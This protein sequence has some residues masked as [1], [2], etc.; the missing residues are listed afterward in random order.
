[1]K[2]II[3]PW[4]V[5][6]V[7]HDSQLIPS[8]IRSQF[9]LSVE[10]L[11]DELLKMT[12]HHT[13]ALFTRGVSKAQ[14]V[15]SKISRLVVDVERFADDTQ[16]SMSKVGMGVIYTRTHNGG[17]L[18]SSLNR[19]QRN[20]L[21]SKWYYPHHLALTQAVESSL[22]SYDKCLVIDCHSFPSMP[23]PYESNKLADRPEICIGT[24]TYHT[25]QKLSEK[26]IGYF[27]N[28][29]LTVKQNTPFSDALVPMPFYLKDKR[30]SSVM[31]EVRR[32]IYL[33]E[34]TALI[35]AN[36]FESLSSSIREAIVECSSHII[37]QSIEKN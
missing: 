25:P 15:H 5:F 1:L 34:N 24:N 27:S 16:E 29:G 7:P 4:F 33:S 17:E 20:D 14:I 37:S 31:I 10:E 6:H 12:D 9:S 8:N 22:K 23:L 18:R 3:P 26:L 35:K 32:D 36:H 13:L 30:V 11:E 21:L 19:T 28:Q 2:T